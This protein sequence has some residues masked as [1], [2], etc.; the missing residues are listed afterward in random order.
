MAYLVGLLFWLGVIAYSIYRWH[1]VSPNSF[2]YPF[3]YLWAVSIG[4]F[5]TLVTLLYFFLVLWYQEKFTYM[6]IVLGI[7]TAA[8]LY[9]QHTGLL[10]ILI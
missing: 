8:L 4:V 3:G 9:L 7:L 5:G 1:T 6:F 10:F 2:M